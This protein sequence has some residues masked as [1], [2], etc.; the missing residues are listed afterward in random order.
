MLQNFTR[1]SALEV[2][3]YSRRRNEI[4]EMEDNLSWLELFS[5]FG[6]LVGHYPVVR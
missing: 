3:L 2:D 4:L 5:I 1:F 6:K